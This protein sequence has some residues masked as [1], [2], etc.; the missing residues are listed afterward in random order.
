LQFSLQ[1]I[2]SGAIWQ[3]LNPASPVPTLVTKNRKWGK[4]KV[5]YTKE[6]VYPLMQFKDIELIFSSFVGIA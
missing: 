3:S 5:K 4:I 2:K 6:V 1:P